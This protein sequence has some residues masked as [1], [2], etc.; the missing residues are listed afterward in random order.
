MCP[1]ASFALQYDDFVPG[2][3]QLQKAHYSAS[4]VAKRVSRGMIKTSI[5]PGH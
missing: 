5:S 4:L 1:S 2:D 3:T